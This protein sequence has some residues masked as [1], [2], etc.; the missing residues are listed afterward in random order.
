MD[1]IGRIHSI[2]TF[3]AV[4]GPG[5]RFII[6]FQGCPLR[7]LYCHNPDSWS[8]SQGKETTP[9]KM[10]AEILKYKSYIKTG[11][12]TLSGG[13]PL[14]QPEFALEIIKECKKNGIH[15][16]IDTSGFIN[17]DNCKKV[18]D[19][20]ELI[21]LDIKDIDDEDC[22]ILTGKGN[23]NMKTLLSYC[24]SIKKPVWIRHVVVPEYTMKKDKLE[25]LYNFIKQY[26]CIEKVEPL[27][28]HKIGEY[29]W[30]EI[31]FDYRL[32]EIREPTKEDME[33]VYKILKIKKGR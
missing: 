20:V 11:G 23:E 14:M 13:E 10:I 33:E 22:M 3:G 21:L 18:I 1:V 16:A 5:I 24:E 29:K 9:S 12:V 27:D 7:C 19:Q 28:F 8:F 32:S 25:K 15:T 4:D 26:K 31:G 2:E 6:F 17:L 30:K